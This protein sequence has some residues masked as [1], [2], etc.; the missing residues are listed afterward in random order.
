M[1]IE[2]H[3]GSPVGAPNTLPAVRAGLASPAGSIEIDVQLTADGHLVCFHH[4]TL[5]E[6]HW[7]HEMRLAELRA[8]VLDAGLP[9]PP[10]LDEVAEEVVRAGKLLNVDVK[11][12]F[13]AEGEPHR[14][15]ARVLVGLGATP[16]AW[17]SDWDHPSLAAVK[18]EFPTVRIRPAVRGR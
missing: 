17:I 8:R 10:A 5:A 18:S 4:F 13:A 9:E 2:S 12:A 3:R 6:R 15:V 7:V 14:A 11:G 1:I 16:R